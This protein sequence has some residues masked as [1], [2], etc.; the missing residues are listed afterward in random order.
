MLAQGERHPVSEAICGGGIRL[1]SACIRQWATRALPPALHRFVDVAP[2][3]DGRHGELRKPPRSQSPLRRVGY[4]RRV[5][6][7]S[8]KF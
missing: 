5:S 2:P 4:E 8:P 6:T 3:E 1:K 7:P